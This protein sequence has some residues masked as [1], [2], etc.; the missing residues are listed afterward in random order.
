MEKTKFETMTSRE[1]ILWL[2]ESDD[3]YGGPQ[4]VNDICKNLNIPNTNVR[5]LVIR[6]MK[7]GK[8]E[9]ISKGVYKIANDSREYVSSKPE[10]K[11]E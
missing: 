9:R 2:L 10:M 8:I 4:S 7:T 1:K 11:L 3:E 5:S 6:M